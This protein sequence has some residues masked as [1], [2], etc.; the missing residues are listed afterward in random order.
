MPTAG[1]A[2]IPH[3]P[4]S[5]SFT[6]VR[7]PLSLK[8]SS[9]VH[10]CPSAGT[11][12]RSSS[13]MAHSR[14]GLSRSAVSTA[15]VA[16]IQIIPSRCHAGDHNGRVIMHLRAAVQQ[17]YAARPSDFMAVRASLVAEAKTAGDAELAR[18]VGKLRKPTVAAW[19]VNHFVREQREDLEELGGF[20]ELLRE[21]QRTLDGDQLRALGRERAAPR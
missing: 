3:R 7:V 9:V 2:V 19:A 12:C 1:S 11:H 18:A 15:H 20:A 10:C 16:Q 13:Q 4:G 17:L 5:T 21:A 14:G 6:T 8:A